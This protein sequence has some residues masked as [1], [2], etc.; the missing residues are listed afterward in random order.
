MGLAYANCIADVF[1]SRADGTI[2]AISQAGSCVLH[3]FSSTADRFSGARRQTC[4]CSAVEVIMATKDGRLTSSGAL[5]V[6]SL[7]GGPGLL[8]RVGQVPKRSLSRFRDVLRC[9][10]GRAG[11][12]LDGRSASLRSAARCLVDLVGSGCSFTTRCLVDL[13]YNNLAGRR[14]CL[15]RRLPTPSKPSGENARDLFFCHRKVHPH[16]YRRERTGSCVRGIGQP[17]L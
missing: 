11:S 7:D 12:S 3:A 13:T 1:S 9:A 5:H 14:S 8:S 16:G 6:T 4:C 10:L 17:A 15:I 2:H